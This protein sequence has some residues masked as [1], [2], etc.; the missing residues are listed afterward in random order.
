M[1]GA[2]G[3]GKVETMRGYT[4]HNTHERPLPAPPA[5]VAALLAGLAGDDD[6]LWPHDAWPAM[7]FDGPLGVGA[8]GGHGPVRYTITA[9][10]PG[11][12][13]R[14]GFTAPRGF[15]GHHEFTVHPTE[16]GTGAGDSTVLVLRHTLAMRARG[17]ATVT[18]PF[19]WRPL[20]DALIEDALDRAESATRGAVAAPA[21]WGWWVRVLRKAAGAAARRGSGRSRQAQFPRRADDQVVAAEHAVGSV[22]GDEAVEGGKVLR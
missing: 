12:R 2:G 5:A 22:V 7:R 17:W 3:P 13:I 16:A 8:A 4:V 1:W 9:Y 15:A 21:L 19:V 18:W 14:F 11:A 6:R 20:H 10:E